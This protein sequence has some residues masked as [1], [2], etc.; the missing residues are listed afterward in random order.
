M[1]IMLISVVATNRWAIQQFRWAMQARCSI[2]AREV[3]LTA[4]GHAPS[5]QA[6]LTAGVARSDGAA[7]PATTLSPREMR[8]KKAAGLALAVL[9]GVANLIT[10]AMLNSWE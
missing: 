8:A 3:Q 9:T 4:Q 6:G 1:H 2:G 10:G 7:S 5:P